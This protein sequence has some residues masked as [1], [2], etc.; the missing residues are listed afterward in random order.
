MIFY[1]ISTLIIVVLLNC[2]H[3]VVSRSPTPTESFGHSVILDTAGKIVLH[4]NFNASHITF[5][6]HGNTRGW[7][8]IGFSENGN[9]IGADIIVGWVKNGIGHLKDHHGTVR[10]E[11]PPLDAKQNV[12]LLA[13]SEAEGWTVLKF[14]RLLDTCDKDDRILTADTTRVIFAYGNSDPQEN[15]I[16]R[17]N[18]HG[19]SRGSKSV[20]F[21]DT[22]SNAAKQR[23]QNE[24][25][26]TFDLLN[27][28]V[29]LSSTESYNCRL[30]KIPDSDSKF[31]VVKV[32][33]VIQPGNEHNI[34]RFVLYLCSEFLDAPT[35]VNMSAQCAD[36][37]T[38]DFFYCTTI[39]FAW[40]VGGGPIV[41]PMNT[42]FPLGG[43]GISKYALLETH[44]VNP[45]AA[46]GIVDSSGL[47]F[48]YT[49][50]LRQ[51]DSGLLDVGMGI[52]PAE[53]IIPPGAVS[54]KSYGECSASCL[55][56]SLK[57][58]NKTSINIFSVLLRGGKLA[59]RLSLNHIRNG[60]ELEPVA[61]DNGYDFN[62]Q[63]T[64]FLHQEK[65]VKSGDSLQMVCDYNSMTR[66][67]ITQGGEN[68][69][70]EVCFSYVYYYPQIRLAKCTTIPEFSTLMRSLNVT[71]VRANV[72]NPTTLY[73]FV[74]SEATQSIGETLDQKNWTDVLRQQLEEISKNALRSQA[75][76]G[77][78]YFPENID[79]EVSPPVITKSYKAPQKNCTQVPQPAVPAGLPPSATAAKTTTAAAPE[80]PRTTTVSPST[81]SGGV[82]TSIRRTTLWTTLLA[83][84]SLCFI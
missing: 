22:P 43:A 12:Q 35:A 39:I 34:R 71:S 77:N 7:V 32:E 28:N 23:P 30:L 44:Y 60:S 62:Y 5:E 49:R 14:Q 73:D 78:D 41:F 54:Y 4:W 3:E 65:V 33:P 81:T 21:M 18:Y 74:D 79:G 31:H 63:E 11:F 17:S 59:K 38:P 47:R 57:E 40:A 50:Q 13:S 6:V 67:N 2:L 29:T 45:G 69:N 84:L 20:V 72:P 58:D 25:H 19:S 68:A 15:D 48:T 70:Q 10:N 66:T 76:E 27:D 64:R 80:T 26:Q 52:A 61:M 46:Q 56:Q 75:C 83:A 16:T 51:Y 82:R 1:Q 42:G 36:P 8:G 24:Q 9:M 53:Q 55:K 37:N